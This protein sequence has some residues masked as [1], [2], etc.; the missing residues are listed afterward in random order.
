MGFPFFFVGCGV[1]ISA[2]SATLPFFVGFVFSGVVG[3][4]ERIDVGGG[5]TGVGLVGLSLLRLDKE[6][7]EL[8]ADQAPSSDSA[9]F[10]ATSCLP[11][12]ISLNHKRIIINDLSFSRPLIIVFYLFFLFSL[13]DYRSCHINQRRGSAILRDGSFHVPSLVPCSP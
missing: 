13:P 11:M 1:F 9:K 3:L 12:L 6:R 2:Y 5:L 4:F 7:V 8:A 10:S